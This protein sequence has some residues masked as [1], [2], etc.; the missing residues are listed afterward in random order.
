MEYIQLLRPKHWV[1]NAFVFVPLF[2]AGDFFNFAKLIELAFGFV[3]FS[4]L[5]SSVYILNDYRDIEAD[6][7]H[8]A[9]RLRPLASGKVSKPTAILLLSVCISISLL[10]GYWLAAKF[11]AILLTYLLLN[12]GYSFGLKRIPILDVMIVSVGFVLRV[13][14]GGAIAE[15]AVSL[16]LTIMVFLLALFMAFAKRRDDVLLKINS[17]KDMREASKNYNLEFLNSCVTLISAVTVVAY[18]MYTLSPLTMEGVGTHRLYI[19]FV[20]VMAGILR[21]L[22]LTY[23]NNQSESPTKILYT[24]RFIQVTILLWIA[25]FYVI[26]YLPPNLIPFW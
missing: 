26:I 5:A 14:A 19:T 7:I 20:F 21:Y 8:P 3:S 22:Q 2:F 12:L 25:A 23:V 24:D 13:K 1:K 6:K 4:F 17:G 18:L 16:W 10:I 15:V 9:K 11:L